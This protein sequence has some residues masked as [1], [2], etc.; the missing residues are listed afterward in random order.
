MIYVRKSE[1]FSPDANDNRVNLELFAD[2]KEDVTPNMTI[3][4]VPGYSI[5]TKDLRPGTKL[6]TSDGEEAYLK[7]DKTWNWVEGGDTPTPT[8][9]ASDLA[10]LGDVDVSSPSDGQILA[11]D[12]ASSKWK[13]T[14]AGGG[15]TV[16]PYRLH[17][18]ADG[19]PYTVIAGRLYGFYDDSDIGDHVLKTEYA[20]AK[21]VYDA[22]GKVLMSAYELWVPADYDFPPNGDTNYVNYMTF[23]DLPGRPGSLSFPNIGT[24]TG[25]IFEWSN[26]IDAEHSELYRFM[27]VDPDSDGYRYPFVAERSFV[28][29]APTY[30]TPFMLDGDSVTWAKILD[31]IAHG[32]TLFQ[33]ESKLYTTIS[34][35]DSDTIEFISLGVG[36]EDYLLVD[37]LRID[38]S[39]DSWTVSE[40]RQIHYAPVTD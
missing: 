33:Y 36:T 12:E 32:V 38:K 3:E 28:S 6:V 2:S 14:A 15:G 31:A 30:S 27:L 22:G 18:R 1:K 34:W 26:S 24:M 17:I 13:N 4:V 5:R 19:F 25:F 37:L 21:A 10:D 40:N 11:Y 29:Y 8:P 7:S 9:G 20:A 16:E 39:G 23:E 35:M